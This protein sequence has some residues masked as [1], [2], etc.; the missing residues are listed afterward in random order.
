M[1]VPFSP[2]PPAGCTDC[3]GPRALEAIIL[4]PSLGT[5]MVLKQGQ[6]KCSLIVG[7]GADALA[8]FDVDAQRNGIAKNG[9]L[10]VD[11]HLRLSAI[12][13]QKP[14]DTDIT[15]G[16]LY[17]DGKDCQNG[18]KHIRVWHLGRALPG[19]LIRDRHGAYAPARPAGGGSPVHRSNGRP[20]AILAQQSLEAVYPSLSELW[21]VQLDLDPLYKKI[22]SDAF[23]N[24][25]WMVQTTKRHRDDADN[26]G[27]FF[28]RFDHH[29]P[30]DRHIDN[31]LRKQCEDAHHHYPHG[32]LYERDTEAKADPRNMDPIN[33][34]DV[35][36]LQSWH[37][38]IRATRLPLKL[39]HVSDVHVN[40]RHHAMSRSPAKVLE[41]APAGDWNRPVGERVCHSYMALKELFQ[42]VGKSGQPDI[43]MLLTGDLLDFNRNIDPADMPTAIGEQW[44]TF[45][46][47]NKVDD[48]TLYKRGMDDIL[49]YSLVRHAYTTLK[50]PVFMP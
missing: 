48:K 2:P 6:R 24:W 33:Q 7:T 15:V 19:K 28:L 47:L 27:N 5:P 3:E 41:D 4:Y 44:K 1:T 18:E 37:P 17:A 25:S 26:R 16:E 40:V 8:A 13:A 11:R 21:E 45:N 46:V 29:E 36:R 9:H 31:F 12:D 14:L 30:Q 39:G 49:V 10:Y 35:Q 20:L 34:K 42:Q 22:G 38:V 32:R 50:L 43:A 23:M